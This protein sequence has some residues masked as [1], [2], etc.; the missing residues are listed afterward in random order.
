[1]TLD[2]DSRPSSIDNSPN[3]STDSIAPAD[4]ENSLT[5]HLNSQIEN[6]DD[7]ASIEE[8][9]DPSTP[10]NRPLPRRAATA[11]ATPTGRS[12]PKRGIQFSPRL[13]FHETWHSAEYDRRGEPATCNNLTFAI[14]QMIKEELNAFKMDEMEV[15]EVCPFMMDLMDRIV[16][17]IHISFDSS[18]GIRHYE[19]SFNNCFDRYFCCMVLSP[20]VAMDHTSWVFN[21]ILY[22][23]FMCD[24]VYASFNG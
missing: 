7:S 9:F 4:L 24:L 3:A 18:M 12:T 8:D 13:E 6:V 19:E 15:H 21:S 10:I 22:G 14:A 23:N 17:I 5:T 16:E 11:P 1:L 2:P 20:R